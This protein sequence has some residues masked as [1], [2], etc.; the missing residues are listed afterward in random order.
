M[1]KTS[2]IKNHSN[3]LAINFATPVNLLNNIL[4]RQFLPLQRIDK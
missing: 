4:S 1:K 2:F 3:N